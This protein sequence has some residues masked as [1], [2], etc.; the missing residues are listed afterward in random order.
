MDIKCNVVVPSSTSTHDPNASYHTQFKGA[1]IGPTSKDCPPKVTQDSITVEGRWVRFSS[2][3]PVDAKKKDDFSSEKTKH[4]S[5]NSLAQALGI[6]LDLDII[7]EPTSTSKEHQELSRG[8]FLK[9]WIPIPTRLFVKKETRVFKVVAKVW[10][11]GDEDLDFMYLDG[12]VDREGGTRED[13]LD[14][15][16][17]PLVGVGEMT[18]SHLR[19]ER[20]LV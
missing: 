12:Q 18:V 1:E 19:G 15:D 16:A 20:M 9:I 2:Y 3:P 13:G 5:R 6:D 10:M 11:M 8:W 7:P 14:G 17:L 4:K